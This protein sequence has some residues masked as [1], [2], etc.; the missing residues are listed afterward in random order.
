M[1]IGRKTLKSQRARSAR[2]DRIFASIARGLLIAYTIFFVA[3]WLSH[4]PSAIITEIAI[5]GVHASDAAQ[6]EAIVDDKLSKPLLY[7]VSRAN[8]WLYPKRAIRKAIF[9]SDA[10]VSAIELSVSPRNRLNIVI[11]E[12]TP[13][14]LWCTEREGEGTT[15]DCYFGDTEGYLFAKAPQYSGAAFPVYHTLLSK[16]APIGKFL[17]PEEE[18]ATVGRFLGLLARMGFSMRSV[19][20]LGEGDY[21][22]AIGRPWSILF[23]TI[24]EPEE[25]ALNL[26]LA[27]N[28][29]NLDQGG[30]SVDGLERIDLRFGNKVFY[31]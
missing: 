10:H 21:Q 11:R 18:Y 23:S 20:E 26:E 7:K 27:L 22:V 8:A 14:L 13:A 1:P 6:I 15:D 24:N 31:K 29:I 19:R 28:S 4:R 9:E 16:E 3:A 17:L 30:I 2:I 12:Y 5:S 25:S